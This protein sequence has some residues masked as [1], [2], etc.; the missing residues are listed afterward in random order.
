MIR[1]PPAGVFERI[2]Q[3]TANDIG[4]GTIPQIMAK[5]SLRLIGPLQPAFQG[6]I[7][8]TAAPTSNATSP[9]VAKAFIAFLISA[10]AKALFFAHGVD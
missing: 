8:Y 4:V 5:K 9:E 10:A 2:S 7:I 1:L 6:H 3:A